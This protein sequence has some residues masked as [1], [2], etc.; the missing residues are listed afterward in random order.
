MCCTGVDLEAMQAKVLEMCPFMNLG[1]TESHLLN[2]VTELKDE[3]E[4]V[5]AAPH[6]PARSRF[7]ACGFHIIDYPAALSIAPSS[8]AAVARQVKGL[9]DIT[10]PDLVHV[11]AAREMVLFIRL[12][13]R[14]TPLIFTPHVYTSALDFI[15]T[16]LF[17]RLADKVICVSDFEKTRLDRFLGGRAGSLT[18]RIYNGIPAADATPTPDRANLH[19]GSQG[20]RG[21]EPASDH[22]TLGCV[23]RLHRGKGIDILLRAFSELSSSYPGLELVIVGE[24]E[25]RVGL[26]EL[27]SRLGIREKVRFTGGLL[28]PMEEVRN[29]DIFVLPSFNETLSMAIIEA[30]WQG[31]PVISTKVGGIPEVVQH[32]RTGLLCRPRSVSDL[33]NALVELIESRKERVIYGQRAQKRAHELFSARKMAIATA[34]IY[35]KLLELDLPSRSG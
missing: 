15:S 1:G 21:V 29:W 27:A 8:I 7:E 6:G 35:K 4:F 32:G 11:H 25:E 16:S 5:I 17:A 34:E 33:K 18:V 23:A 2:L 14:S 12:A 28:H 20:D 19:F 26:E 22:M 9:L 30:M 13:G 10:D 3:F 24:G 31:K